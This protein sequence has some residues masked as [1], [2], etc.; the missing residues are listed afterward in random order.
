L[1]PPFDPPV[2]IGERGAVIVQDAAPDAVELGLRPLQL[3]FVLSPASN[4]STRL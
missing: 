2:V 3:E 1:T 4:S